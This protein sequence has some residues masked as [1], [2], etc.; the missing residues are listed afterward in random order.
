MREDLQEVESTIKAEEMGRTAPRP[1]G[2][3]FAA[4]PDGRAK[5]SDNC[6]QRNKRFSLWKCTCSGRPA[7]FM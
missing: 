5:M 3:L 7:P 2:Y 4:S 1:L 6:T